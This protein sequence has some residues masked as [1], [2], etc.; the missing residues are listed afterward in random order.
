MGKI[1]RRYEDTSSDKEK[2][3]VSSS[4]ESEGR[5]NC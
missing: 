2:E 1:N 3:I 5:G 4:L